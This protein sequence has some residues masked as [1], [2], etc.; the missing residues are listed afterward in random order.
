M[1]CIDH[2]KQGGK[3]GYANTYHNGRSRGLHCLAYA[4]AHALPVEALQ[5]SVVRHTCDNPRCINPKHLVIGT[6]QDNSN[7]MKARKRSLT[8]SRNP[9]AVLTEEDVA[10]I[11]RIHRKGCKQFGNRPLGRRYGVTHAT[12]YYIVKNKSWVH[13]KP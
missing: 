6:V 1:Q 10:T 7:D 12:I 4:K 11:R 2:G 9:A 13:P 5:G 8:C 3:L